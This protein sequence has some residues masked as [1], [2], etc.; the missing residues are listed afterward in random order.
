MRLTGAL[1][2]MGTSLLGVLFLAAGCSTIKVDSPH[3]NIHKDGYVANMTGSAI[4]IPAKKKEGQTAEEREVEKLIS[5]ISDQVTSDCQRPDNERAHMMLFVHGGMTSTRAAMKNSK[6]LDKSGVFSKRDIRPIYVNWN[7]NLNS[8]MADDVLWVRG[9]K[10]TVE[11]VIV[12]PIVIAWRLANGVFNALPNWYYQVIDESRFFQDWPAEEPPIGQKVRD[13]A[14]GLVHAPFS[15]VSTPF[16][17]GFGQG[18]WLM[19]K[20]RIDM[21]FSVMKGPKRFGFREDDPYPGVMR[22]LLD[23]LIR[24]RADWEA[25]CN[26]AFELDFV[27]H[28]M[29]ALVGTRIL[30]EYPSLKFDRVVFLA[31]AST[32]EDYVSTIPQYLERQQHSAF[33]SFNLSI[34]DE[35]NEL[36]TKSFVLP[37]G[38]LLVW[39]DNFLDPVLSPE[40]YR[41]GDSYNESIFGFPLENDL[42]CDRMSMLK[43]SAPRDQRDGWPRKHGDFND[44]EYL[45]GLLDLTLLKNSPSRHQALIDECEDDC[46]VFAPCMSC[47]LESESQCLK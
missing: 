11:G 14:V 20:R 29:G 30:H 36:T 8:A 43:V 33:Y 44:P 10:R 39:I 25:E 2:Y 38:S 28:S 47:Y 23:E 9:G 6:E 31:A 32:V 35:G 27:G 22:T 40:D 24:K 42:R 45:G 7:S 46:V 15:I 1:T 26:G 37:R 4:E 18:A 16:L 21:M 34:I 41:V 13:G 12:A 3:L 19:M 5:Q 17:T